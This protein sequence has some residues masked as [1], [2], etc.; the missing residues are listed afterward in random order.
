MLI[1]C[2]FL[3]VGKLTLCTINAST[4]GAPKL[5]LDDHQHSAA[6]KVSPKFASVSPRRGDAICGSVTCIACNMHNIYSTH[7]V[8]SPSNGVLEPPPIRARYLS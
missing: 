1:S 5:W 2:N 6:S 4:G 8:L 3:S 7:N